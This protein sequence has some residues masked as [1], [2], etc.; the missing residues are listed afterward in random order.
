M[1]RGNPGYLLAVKDGAYKGKYA[2]ARHA[3]Q[4]A[5]FQRI[6]KLFVELYEDN[7]TW[8]PMLQDGKKLVTL[9]SK[10]FVDVIGMC[11]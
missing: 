4:D 5:A 3:K 2:I 7:V 6:N 10:D 8:K 11:D 9:I 1:A